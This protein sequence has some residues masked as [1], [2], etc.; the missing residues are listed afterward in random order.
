[1]KRLL[2]LLSPRRL[3]RAVFVDQ[4]RLRREGAKLKIDLAARDALPG[5]PPATG[6]AGPARNTPASAAAPTA[7]APSAQAMRRA[8]G[9]LLDSRPD[10]RAVLKHLAALEHQLAVQPEPFIGDL[11]LSSLQL[12]LRQLRGLVTPPPAPGV[13]RLLAEL[14]EAIEAK[15]A[16]ITA[17]QP[18]V[19]PISSFFV[20]H[21]V[22]VKELVGPAAMDEFIETQRGSGAE[23]DLEPL[24]F[25]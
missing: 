4:L 1:M 9:A 21:K 22:E 17:T 7:A 6:S 8:L 12:M 3:L 16:E 20:D 13:A 2:G 24:K 5:V 19:Q 25:E 10:S 15:S 14:G 18:G 11:S 23:L